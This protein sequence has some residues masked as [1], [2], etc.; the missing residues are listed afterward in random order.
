VDIGARADIYAIVRKAVEAGASVLLVASD[1]AELARVS[2]RVI[3]LRDGQLVADVKAPDL[4]QHVL[5]ELA[6]KG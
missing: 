4:D 5:T 6:Y 2:D 3:V 1:F